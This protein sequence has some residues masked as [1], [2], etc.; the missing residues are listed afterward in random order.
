MIGASCLPRS[1]Q[2]KLSSYTISRQLSQYHR[3]VSVFNVRQQRSLVAGGETLLVIRPDT[4]NNKTNCIGK[5]HWIMRC[6]AWK[7]EHIV[8]F[9][10]DV[11]E[12]GAIHHLQ[13]HISLDLIEILFRAVEMVVGAL[14]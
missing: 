14:V 9:N 13:T 2:W 11:F 6:I 8:F 5:P 7:Q 10:Y 3:R 4:L 1:V 12:F